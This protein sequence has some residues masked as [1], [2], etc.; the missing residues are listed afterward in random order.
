MHPWVRRKSGDYDYFNRNKAV[1]GGRTV[2]DLES[3]AWH[4][5]WSRGYQSED[6]RE[7]PRQL[8][9]PC[10]EVKISSDSPSDGDREDCL[11]RQRS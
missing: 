9:G 3:G 8:R 1:D 5:F 7:V 11:W 4:A 10:F 6:S 2:A